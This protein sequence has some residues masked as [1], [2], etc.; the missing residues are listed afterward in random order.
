MSIYIANAVL[1]EV[2]KIFITFV[3]VNSDHY[4]IKNEGN[5]LV[6]FS[7]THLMML[8]LHLTFTAKGCSSYGIHT[9]VIQTTDV[10]FLKVTRGR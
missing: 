8:T 5:T 2:D 9:S 4:T 10:A 6:L 3:E 1:T 7:K